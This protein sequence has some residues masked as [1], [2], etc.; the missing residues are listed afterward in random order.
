MGTNADG[1]GLIDLKEVGV[2]VCGRVCYAYYLG[3]I[4]PGVACPESKFDPDVPAPVAFMM[5]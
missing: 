1:L 3:V 5:A 4:I 2:S